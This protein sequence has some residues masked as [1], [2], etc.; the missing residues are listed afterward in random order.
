MKQNWQYPELMKFRK[1][2]LTDYIKLTNF[3]GFN[4][5]KTN[6]TRG[7]A[8]AKLIIL[9]G[10]LLVFSTSCK[11]TAP[12]PDWYEFMPD[13]DFSESVI[14][15]SDWLDQP[16]GL[17]GFISMKNGDYVYE[18]GEKVKFWGVNI[19]SARPYS[20]RE[21]VDEWV[22]FLKKYG[23][24]AVRFHKY[25]Q[26]GLR[27]D[28]STRLEDDKQEKMDYFQ[29]RLKE[30]G[31]YYG[32][33][34]IYGHKLRPGDKNR[35]LAYDEI[36]N[37]EMNS[38]LSNST[39]GLVN[40]ADDIQDLHIELLTNLLS[41]KNPYTGL[42]Y[43]D[44]PALVF[45]EIQNEDNIWFSTLEKNLENCPIYKAL[46]TE[47]FT[48]WLRG[49]YQNQKNL[50][51]AWG[52][53]AL[54]WGEE[55]KN[56]SWDLDKAN[57]CP[58]ASH[59]IY[60]Y[61]FEKAASAG[62]KLPLF[63][64]DMAYFLYLEQVEFYNKTVAAIRNTGYKGIII[65][66]CWQAGAGITHYYNLHADYVVGAIDR[67]NYYGGG[68]GHRLV[69][70]TF[71]NA[72]MLT[73][74]GS[75]LLN[76]GR[77]AVA[78]R[79]FQFSEWMSLPPNEWIAEGPP[80]VAVYGLGL[81]GWD[82][83]Y[84]FA[85]DFPDYTETIHTPG[86]YNVNTPTQIGLYPGL[87]AMIYRDEIKEGKVVA[88]RNVSLSSLHDGIIGFNEQ[89]KQ[90]WD[91]KIFSGGTPNEYFAAGKVEIDFRD[92]FVPTEIKQISELWDTTAKTVLSNTG[93]LFWDYSGKGYFTANTEYSR[94]LTGFTANQEI[95]I[96]DIVFRTPNQFA[97]A[98]LTSLEKD[99]DLSTTSRALL[100]TVARAKN[101]GMQYND[102]KT[103]IMNVGNAPVMLESVILNLKFKH[104]KIKEV[105][106]LDHVG[107]QTGRK[108]DVNK[109]QFLFDG[110]EFN[111]L[112]YEIIF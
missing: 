86:V 22:Q 31:I 105:N 94:V 75:G 17:H 81:Q 77:Q 36:A 51:N 89:V 8:P 9:A 1:Q 83:S 4:N 100:T 30:N 23:V 107:R 88:E 15:M 73:H 112:Y 70:G 66:S 99:Q 96:G 63:L 61:E 7:F 29:F 53:E 85:S 76:T 34:P 14:D 46:L 72:S 38:H 5:L 93:Q 108:I 84:A 39:I 111:T 2:Q 87:S 16:A 28:I 52:E 56:I 32:W 67:H 80:L 55:V 92:E 26:H 43:S 49:R 60:G 18:D 69:P 37:S 11:N 33:S 104:R 44:D 19:C 62:E 13:E 20:D 40:F 74:P 95:N 103:E 48:R 102:D 90:D 101:T 78:D 106:V 54:A 64:R 6:Q 71:K 47:K 57:I 91:Q 41:H 12:A 82:A 98:I 21:V 58:V 79:A 27:N 10:M 3:H 109:K 110:N 68:T 45:I 35:L 59:G 65:G 97:V 24:N 25:T 50:L 42:K